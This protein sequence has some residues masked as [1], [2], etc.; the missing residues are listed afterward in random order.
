MNKNRRFYR[1]VTVAPASGRRDACGT[2]GAGSDGWQVLLDGKP[3]LTPA[4]H[5]VLLPAKP[6]AEAIAAEW[7]GQGSEI[8]SE[9]MPFTRLANTA[10]DRVAPD[11]RAAIDEVLKY[12]GSDLLCFRAS[13][14]DVLV[15]RQNAAWDP[16]LDWAA[17]QYG[18]ELQTVC[19]IAPMR[20]SADELGALESFII[21]LD[22]FALTGL[23]AAAASLGSA[24]L[25][26]ALYE[27]RIGPEE[28]FSSSELDAVYQAEIWGK[29]PLAAAR[30]SRKQKEVFEISEFFLLTRRF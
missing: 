11:R 4:G 1:E 8:R 3:A 29:D 16:L 15:E 25:A 7:E 21:Q 6:L 12:A 24:I 19:G 5:P 20:Q 27:R 22:D 10:I 13:A 18:I 30:N 14:P 28:A 2:I 9:I 23:V 17:E 26:L